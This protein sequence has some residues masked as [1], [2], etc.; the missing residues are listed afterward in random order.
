M[1]RRRIFT[2]SYT[3]PYPPI[4]LSNIGTK[5]ARKERWKETVLSQRVVDTFKE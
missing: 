3:A 5:E 4:N 1:L 2:A